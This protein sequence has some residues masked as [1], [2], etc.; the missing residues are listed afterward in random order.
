MFDNTGFCSKRRSPS[1]TGQTA[2]STADYKKIESL[3]CLRHHEPKRQAHLSGK[4][5]FLSDPLTE[6]VCVTLNYGSRCS[7]SFWTDINRLETSV[8]EK[9][10]GDQVVSGKHSSFENSDCSFAFLRSCLTKFTFKSQILIFIFVQV[11]T[12]RERVFSWYFGV[13]LLRRICCQAG[14]LR[15]YLV[16]YYW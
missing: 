12:D 13:C 9:Q 5:D 15:C 14:R 6:N 16:T 7:R 1:C 2:R 4:Y 10:D 11:K 3:N 8:P